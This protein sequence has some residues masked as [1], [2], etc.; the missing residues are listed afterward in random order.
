ML[1]TIRPFAVLLLLGST[2]TAQVGGLDAAE[3]GAAK[4][5][6]GRLLLL[7]AA[8]F[9]P[10]VEKPAIP[11][12]LTWRKD[13]TAPVDYYVVQ[14]RSRVVR[15]DHA[16][17]AALGAT[18]LEYLADQSFLVRVGTKQ[19]P[20]IAKWSRTR[21]V[22]PFEP[23][24]R[25]DPELV[26]QA[27]RLGTR[28]LDVAIALFDGADPLDATLALRAAGVELLDP[29]AGASDR[30][31]ARLPAN[32]LAAAAH[33]R[34]VQW[35]QHASTPHHRNNTTKWVIQS[36]VSGSTPVW[37][38]GLLGDNE[39]V[40][41]ID[42]AIDLGSCWFNDPNNPNPGPSHRKIV[43]HHGPHTSPDDHG[44]HT[45]GT[46]A[47]DQEPI[48]GVID[49]N[50][51][52]YHAKIAHTNLDKITATNLLTKLNELYTDGARLFS[53]SWGD[54]S[55]TAYDQWCHDVDK[56]QN[57]NQ[58]TLVFF[59]V[60]D[61]STIR[62]PENAKNLVAVSASDQSP[63][64]ANS[65]VGGVGPTSDGRRK[66]EVLAPGCGINSAWANH[67]C[68]TVSF[69]GTSMACPAVT[70]AATLVKQYFADGWYPSGAANAAD[71]FSASG[72]LVKAVLVD[73]SVDM[74]GI[75]G[76]PSNTEGWGRLLLDD[77]LYF[78]GD[79]RRLW[80][81][82]VVEADGLATTGDTQEHFV[83][84]NSNTQSLEI[85][86]CFCDRAGATN[87]SAPV[88][89]DLDLQ[90]VD[91]NGTTYLGN[92][93]ANG[94]S[95]TG[96][97]PDPLN[98]VERVKLTSPVAGWYTVTISAT[99]IN[100]TRLQSYALVATGDVDPP[101]IG[102][103]TTYGTGS[104]G[105]GGF[106]PAIAGVGEPRIN[107]DVEVDV[108]NA[109]G[110][111]SGIL[112]VGVGRWNVPYAGGFLLVQ[113]PWTVFPFALGGAPGVG[114]AGSIALVDTLPADPSLVG[115]AVD[116]QADVLDH[117]A[118]LGM[119]L[120]NGLEMTIGS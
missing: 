99:A 8:E 13:E 18:E 41:H 109:L 110:G 6:D 20:A 71:G 97:S 70:G 17:L 72:T 10:L 42:G 23:A 11:A 78:S 68:S 104:A 7:K 29:D 9:D 22:V 38:Q 25:V 91:P 85:C 45:A 90:V 31:M 114:G 86:L 93:F 113:P 50:G 56:F 36:N 111:A 64:Q 75:S 37:N 81:V 66:P 3:R 74:T 16:E 100:T 82:D 33:V 1:S 119:A 76:Y 106:V 92:V 59:A 47:G 105:T 83:H 101:T 44:T 21:A 79:A 54:D 103:F 40:G 112:I 39:I 77:A 32:A 52:G 95:T 87:S 65:C 15:S 46:A 24:Y 88:I 115:L 96:G 89:N 49:Y 14:L 107:Q 12:A 69:T 55:T 80:A 35:I 73:S 53:N 5:R 118:L 58:D 84:V 102:G 63:N 26:A 48:N 116:L 67:T 28:P 108:S 2:A 60:S 61:L 51:M 94:A 98:N 34:D 30:L 43:S 57:D 120:S 117:G 19:L 62:N 4:V 27:A